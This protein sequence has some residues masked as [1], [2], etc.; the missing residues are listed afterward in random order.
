MRAG[1]LGVALLCAMGAVSP[2][3]A[4]EVQGGRVSLTGGRR[5]LAAALDGPTPVELRTCH[6][7]CASA[8]AAS[9][10]FVRFGDA[11]HP[12]IRLLI[13]DLEPPIDLQRLRFAAELAGNERA[14]VATFQAD[15]PVPGVRLVKSFEVSRDGYEV[16]MADRLGGRDEPA[17][18]SCRE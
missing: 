4:G 10:T 12:P 3:S 7:S 11:D 15:L 16:V 17:I 5:A 8:D 18:M 13:R 2:V 6:P 14:R 1:P 9:G